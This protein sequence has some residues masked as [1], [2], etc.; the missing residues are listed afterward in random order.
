M[1]LLFKLQRNGKFLSDLKRKANFPLGFDFKLGK[2][3][4]LQSDFICLL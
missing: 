3:V 4:Y 2:R 1:K